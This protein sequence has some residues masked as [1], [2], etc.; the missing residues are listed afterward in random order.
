MTLTCICGAVENEEDF[1]CICNSDI[2]TGFHDHVYELLKDQKQQKATRK[3]D[4]AE[5]VSLLK[6]FRNTDVNEV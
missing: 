4:K 6:S 2:Y 5:T 3:R 1:T